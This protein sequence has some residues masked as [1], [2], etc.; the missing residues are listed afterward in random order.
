MIPTS[1]EYVDDVPEP[2]TD[3]SIDRRRF[4]MA[5]AAAGMVAAL[6]GEA[7]AEP[8]SDV[9]LDDL[10][11]RMTLQE[12]AGQLHMEGALSPR[13]GE[14]DFAK[15]N[16]FFPPTTEAA[17]KAAYAAQL[18]RVRAGN[19]G[20][21]MTPMDLDSVTTMQRTAVDRSR[22]KIPLM[23]G[24]DIIHGR[25]TVFP[26][27]VAEAASFEPELARRTARAC[28][29]EAT[30]SGLDLTF[31]PMVDIARDQRWGRVV[32]GA[33]EDVLLG[34]LFAA[35]RVRGFQGDRRGGADSL[36]ACPKHF[37]AYGAAESGLD[38][39]GNSISERMLHE[40]Y[41]PPFKAAFDAGAILT[42]ASFNTIDGVPSTGNRHLLTD[43][44]RGEL[45]F[46]GAVISDY[47]SEKE[48]VNHGFAADDR[49]AARL[50][51]EAGCDIGMVSGIFPRY[52][53]GL[54]RSGALQMEVLDRAVRRVLFVKKE[55]GLFEDP[56]RRIDKRRYAVPAPA[57][58]RALAREAAHKSVVLL[59]NEGDL[60]PLPK[61]GQRV[62]LI[63]P[64]GADQANLDGPWSPLVP[65]RPAIPLA[66]GIQA[67]MADPALLT[68]VAGS[69]ADAP[70]PGGVEAAVAAAQAADVVI[71]AIGE[72]T[73]MSGESASRTD[74]IIPGAQ[75]A[76]AEAVAA[77]AKP[78]IVVLRNG[79]ALA[80][81]GAV[82]DAR[83]ILVGWFLGT[84]TG[85]ALADI[86]FGDASPSGRLPMTWPIATGQEPYYYARESSG[87]AA[88]RG[89]TAKFKSHF[90]GMADAPLYPFGHGLSYA[91]V[92]YGP[93]RCSTPNLTFSG[94]LTVTANVSNLGKRPVEEVVQLYVHDR[95]ASIVQPVRRLIAFRKIVLA[96][97]E[98]HSID[99]PL[100]AADL[101]HLGHDLRPSVEKSDFDV[102][103]APS[104][105][106]G[107][108][109]RFT[110]A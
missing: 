34:R 78:M 61:T 76:L 49:D 87:R 32:E 6:A 47:E 73:E 90:L 35:A 92:A 7:E 17:A 53:P 74:I 23:F 102:W 101:R 68:V 50:A 85:P 98:T 95:V 42:M 72:T 96:P 66:A 100:T 107:E 91:P 8:T 27:P 11:G 86:L 1:A 82:R 19:I 16:P 94:A 15:M 5:A 12:K 63:G 77:T 110:L 106:A 18:E 64:F 24:T 44:L 9:V 22:L 69:G 20:T 28:A 29:I 14:P 31:A 38:Y 97:G 13:M 3:L 30:A 67:A 104:A 52:L 81:T 93:T 65:E 4:L 48:L 84:E 75:Q 80:L 26:V 41:L 105:A 51:L 33:G 45:G 59:K 57:A 2:M 46:Q 62:A 71:L 39:A 108:P 43:I 21:L 103:I 56:F 40:V 55:A 25:L 60:L 99:F 83:A 37:A 89:S 10:V 109:A 70:I 88:E 36:L 54:V 58:H 79:R